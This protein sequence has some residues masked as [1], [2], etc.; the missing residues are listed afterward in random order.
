MDQQQLPQYLK[1][2]IASPKEDLFKGEALSVSSANSSGNFDILPEHA[3]F[4]TLVEKRPIVVRTINEK[5]LV[6]NFD[7]AIIHTANNQVNI[8]TDIQISL[9]LR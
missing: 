4:I 5:P 2:R 8:Y 9:G 1:V 7:L 6:F 3:N